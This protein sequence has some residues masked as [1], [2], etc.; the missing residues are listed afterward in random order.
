VPVSGIQQSKFFVNFFSCREFEIEKEKIFSLPKSP[1]TMAM[2]HRILRG[3]LAKQT[4]GILLLLACCS[5][6]FNLVEGFLARSPWTTATKS[7]TADRELLDRSPNFVGSRRS[8]L[9]LAFEESDD[10]S[11]SSR[12][13]S[14]WLESLRARQLELDQREQARSTRL[15]NAE[16]SGGVAAVIPDWVRRLDVSYPLLACGSSSGSIYVVHLERGGE[17]IATSAATTT[18]EGGGSESEEEDDDVDAP[19]NLAEI[20]R[21]LYGSF[22]GGGTIAIAFSGTLICDAGRTG[23][24]N[25]WR[26]DTGSGQLVSQGS[27]QALEGLLVTSLHIDEEFLWVATSDGRIQ[28]YPLD[29]ELPLA[30][31]MKPVDEWRVDSPILSMYVNSEMG[32]LVVTTASGSIELISLDDDESGR[33]MGSFMPPYD[34]MERR[35]SNAYAMSCTMVHHNGK[36]CSIVCGGHDGCLYIQPLELNEDGQVNFERPFQRQMRQLSPRHMAAV[37]CLVSPAPGLLISGGQDSTMK[38]WDVDEDKFLYQF[39]GYKGKSK[40]LTADLALFSI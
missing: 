35:S 31:Q 27:I 8:I 6:R 36:S 14:D 12:S 37:K 16:C 1:F 2:A 33:P 30:L 29:D 23:G 10:T 3:K 7:L 13:S 39:V 18:T 26:L 15:R 21:L 25:L 28:S 9:S 20:L 19:E 38:M 32:S 11:E 4:R 24:V 5:W 17:V 34:S 22:D 40:P